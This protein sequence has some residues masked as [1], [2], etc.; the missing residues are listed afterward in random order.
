MLKRDKYFVVISE[1][2]ECTSNPCVNGGTCVNLITGYG[3][4]CMKDFVGKNCESELM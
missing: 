4:R 3:C 2:D 1:M